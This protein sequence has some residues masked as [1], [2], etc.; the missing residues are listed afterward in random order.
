MNDPRRPRQGWVLVRPSG[1]TRWGGE[2]RRRHIFAALARRTDAA[3][4]DIW[5]KL[6]RHVVGRRWQ[7]W[8]RLQTRPMPFLVSVEQAP[9][10]WIVKIPELAIPVAVAIYDDASA[11]LQALGVS[12]AESRIA[13]LRL[14]LEQNRDLFHTLVAPTASFAELA[15]LPADRVIIGGNGTI[16]SHIRPRPWPDRPS[17]G[18]VSGA[19]PGRGIELLIEAARRLRLSHP[20]LELHLWLQPTGDDGVGY[21]SD[22]RTGAPEA[23]IHIGA[24]P[25]ASLGDALGRATVLTIPHPPGTY[26]DVALP[27]KLFDS[28]AAGR[29]LVVTPRLEMARVVDRFGVGIVAGGDHVD[30][31]AGAIDRLLADATLA[32]RLGTRARETAVREFDW[33]IL[34]N[35]IADEVLRR[36]GIEFG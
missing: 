23:W 13:G 35:R 36:E 12:V 1:E 22:L 4:I 2:I 26:M 34:G 28:M 14:R 31:L 15:G 25:Y 24:A 29:P 10:S 21:L 3:V 16:V 18:M 11:Q 17:I 33:P 7:L 30:D 27:V 9:P 20:D 6:R 19:A 8:R 32:R 5:P